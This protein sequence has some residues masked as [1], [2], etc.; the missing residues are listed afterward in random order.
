MVCVLVVICYLIFSFV[1]ICEDYNRDYST[2]V[3]LKIILLVCLL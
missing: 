1:D 2:Q 3:I